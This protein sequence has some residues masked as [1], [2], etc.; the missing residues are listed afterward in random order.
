ME[1]K[2]CSDGSY[3]SRTG[4]SCTFAACPHESTDP[5]ALITVSGS[6]SVG[7]TCPVM[8]N[9]PDPQCADKPYTGTLTLTNTATGKIYTPSILPDG[10]FTVSLTRGVYD[11]GTASGSPF[12]RCS[13]KVEVT[14]PSAHI[15]IVC[16]SGIR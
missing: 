4:P 2:Q 11:V 6:A 14:G 9:P 5:G 3:V 16:D 1:A 7:P 13:G 10:T 15:P 8:R 12:P